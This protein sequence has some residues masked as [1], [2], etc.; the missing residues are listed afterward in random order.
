MTVLRSLIGTLAFVL[1]VCLV[2]G[3]PVA[4]VLGVITAV[5]IIAVGARARRRQRS[6]D[7]R[8]AAF[9]ARETARRAPADPDGP[10]DAIPAG[11]PGFRGSIRFIPYDTPT[12]T[13]GNR[14]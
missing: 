2:V 12:D 8:R 14:P 4:G 13:D 11:Y 7:E 5:A 9:T 6:R 10:H 1:A 3:N